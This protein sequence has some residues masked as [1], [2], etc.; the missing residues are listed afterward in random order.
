V[1]DSRKF[2]DDYLANLKNPQPSPNHGS[3]GL[4]GLDPEVLLEAAF[5]KGPLT[6]MVNRIRE[7]EVRVMESPIFLEGEFKGEKRKGGGYKTYPIKYLP[8]F[9][10]E[11]SLAVTKYDLRVRQEVDSNTVGWVFYIMLEAFKQVEVLASLVSKPKTWDSMDKLKKKL[12]E[13]KSILL[14]DLKNLDRKRIMRD[15][16][17]DLMKT[18]GEQLPKDVPSN[19][20][21]ER[22]AELLNFFNIK[23]HIYREEDLADVSVEG[24]R[25]HF[26]RYFRPRQRSNRS[27]NLS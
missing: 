18:C 15:L 26:S 4:S 2:F 8:K 11:L 9:V 3:Y 1:S 19:T 13:L 20:V 27:T 21:G 5:T 23:H 16:R 12:K 7:A 6:R 17:K 10:S 25:K 24:M 14:I 22:M